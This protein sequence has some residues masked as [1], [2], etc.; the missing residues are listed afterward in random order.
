MFGPLEPNHQKIDLNLLR[1]DGQTANSYENVTCKRNIIRQ[2]PRSIHV[3]T[4]PFWFL[5]NLPQTCLM[6]LYRPTV[7]LEA[8]RLRHEE[9]RDRLPGTFHVV[10]WLELRS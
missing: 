9:S 1:M 7:A 4:D 5:D 8:V 3:A 2:K 10:L 6:R